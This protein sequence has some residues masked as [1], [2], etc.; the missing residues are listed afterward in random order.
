MK[1]RSFKNSLWLVGLFLLVMASCRAPKTLMVEKL[2]PVSSNKLIRSIEENAFDHS[3]LDIRRIACQYETP[4][5]KT[6]FRASLKW[7]QDNYI[8]MN[9]SKMNIP[10]ARLL[11]SPDSVKMVNF[12]EKNYFLGDYAFLEKFIS[13]DIDFDVVQSII[14]NDVFS[15][16]DDPKDNDFKEF[17]SY[18]DSGMYV[19]Q[20]LK[21]RKLGKIQRKGKEEKIDR[22]LKKLDEEDF[23]VQ[24][25]Y[26]DPKTFKVRKIILDDPLNSR[27]VQVDFDDFVPVEKQLYPGSIDVHFISPENDLKMKLKLS[28]FSTENDPDINF[29]IPGKYKQVN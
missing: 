10:V 7:E 5:N 27:K 12:L 28:K 25:L 20:S 18:T 13:A 24:Y 17:V 14:T 2:R 15:Y 19:L 22:Y 23:V 11:L 21:N 26:V 8:F 6:S 1:K 16:R 3:S 4:G 9:V 29:N